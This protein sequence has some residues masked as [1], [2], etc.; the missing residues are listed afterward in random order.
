LKV[1]IDTNVVLDVLLERKP[2]VE[3]AVEVFGL[4]ERSRIEAF[5]GATTITTIHYLLTKALSSEDTR[6]TLGKLLSLFEVAVVNRPVLERALAS[7][8]RDF[9]D[10]VLDEAAQLAGAEVIITRNAKDFVNSSLK[11]FEPMDF[12]AQF[13]A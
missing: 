2:F 7:N 9:E 10:A 8:I 5:L 4:V 1:I 3:S 12:I 13:E 11:V 6:Q